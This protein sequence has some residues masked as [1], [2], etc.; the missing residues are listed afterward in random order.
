MSE[1]L[2]F[3]KF[4]A[5]QEAEPLIELLR[6]EQI[7]YS[8]DHEKEVID[9]VY[10]GDNF[11][12]LFTVNIPQEKFAFVQSLIDNELGSATKEAD[13]TH[14]LYSFT[15]AELLDVINNP[16]EWNQYDQVLSRQI[17]SERGVEIPSDKKEPRSIDEYTPSSVKGFILV[18]GYFAAFLIP[19]I[20]VFIGRT[21]MN[22][23]KTLR[24][25]RQVKMY[26]QSTI[27]HG[28]KIFVISL[29]FLAF[30]L[31]LLIRRSYFLTV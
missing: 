1:L 11:D 19:L 30:Y 2:A 27:K 28:E 22:S 14:Y 13:P 7:P 18:R 31:Y 17:L 16:N 8:I 24:S 26:D 5:I 9:R 21:L 12:P 10:I 3:S 23:T 6:R 20:G 4:F 15:D 29:I 25:G